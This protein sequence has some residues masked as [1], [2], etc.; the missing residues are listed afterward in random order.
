MQNKQGC[1]SKLWPFKTSPPRVNN[2]SGEAQLIAIYNQLHQTLDQQLTRRIPRQQLEKEARDKAYE[3]GRLGIEQRNQEARIQAIALDRIATEL[4]QVML[5][6]NLDG[7]RAEKE[8]D[9]QKAIEL[10]EA[11]VQDQFMG[12]HPYERLRIIY[13]KQKRLQDAK[14]ICQAAINNPF[15]DEKKKAKFQEWLKK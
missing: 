7:E 13:R 11:N 4:S 2:Q 3:L 5:N 8:S 1:L 14:R 10:Y 6:R 9:L 12:G 15:L